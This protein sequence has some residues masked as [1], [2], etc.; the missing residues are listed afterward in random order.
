[1]DRESDLNEG[2]PAPDNERRCFLSLPPGKA[3]DIGLIT[4]SCYT[5]GAFS[6]GSIIPVTYCT[7]WTSNL[8]PGALK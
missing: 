1:M 4:P 7:H 6:Y 3:P 5:G 8:L 2:Q